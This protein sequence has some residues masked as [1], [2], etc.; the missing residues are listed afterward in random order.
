MEQKVSNQNLSNLAIKGSIYGGISLFISKFGGL[1]FTIIIAR[2]LLPELFGVYA[3]ALSIITIFMVFTNLGLDDTFLR[4]FSKSLVKN[5]K[6]ESRGYLRYLLKLKLSISLFSVI[7]LLII[8]RFLAY[9]VYKNPLLFYPLIFSC[10]FILSESM[11]TFFA[12]IFTAK[13]DFKTPL[14]FTISL[15]I[16]NILLSLFAILILLDSFKIS[17]IF[18]AFFI[19]SFFTLILMLYILIKRDK[20]L[21]LGE[22]SKI[23]KSKINSYWKF[24]IL[25]N[26]S[27]AFFGS[28][29]ILMLGRF[30]SSDYLGYYRIALSLVI[31]VASLFS[32]SG[33]FLP[34]FTQISGKR[35]IRGFHR[36]LRYILILSIP[37]T[38][39]AIFLAKYL[40]KAIYGNEYILG[41]TSIYFLAFLII[42]TPLIGLYSIIFQSKEKP[43]IVS[44]SILISLLLNILFN[45]FV[46]LL[47]KNNPLFMIAGV[48]LATSLSRIIL[49]GLL[50]F[51]ARKEFNFKIRGIGLRTPIFAT[52]IMSVFLLFFNYA[53]D[54]NIFFGIIEVIVG[55][56]IYFG[57]L[58]LLKGL[59]EE[60]FK[61]IKSLILKN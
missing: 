45:I 44:N 41:A 5:N 33:L 26:I 2:T 21:V 27:L 23:N 53:I 17:G 48:G 1:I 12:T 9:S 49:L 13:K 30:V 47:F 56:G 25:A 29:D 60:D 52:I 38:A 20:E 61:L 31:T 37:A 34:I 57:I 16:L 10:L 3:L 43:K 36:T 4:Y 15:Q 51:N 7:I 18:I 24:M 46:I 59:T 19:S 42:T 8:S 55:A 11:R 54:I 28:I 40:I 22:K 39:G 6:D 14:L 50:V 58:I 32:L 35:F